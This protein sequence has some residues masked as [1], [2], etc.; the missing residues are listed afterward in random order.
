MVAAGSLTA[1][2]T[3][4]LIKINWSAKWKRLMEVMLEAMLM[5]DVGTTF[6][7]LPFLLV[8]VLAKVCRKRYPK[9]VGSSSYCKAETLDMCFDLDFSATSVYF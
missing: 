8:L 2:H 5:N 4:N 9:S 1:K 3:R 7:F 6:I